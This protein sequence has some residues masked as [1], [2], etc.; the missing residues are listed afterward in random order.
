M[1]KLIR[2][3][4]AI[5][6]LLAPLAATAQPSTESLQAD[7]SNRFTV[8]VAGP[9]DA[10]AGIV[11]V[12]DWFGVS[13][14]YLDATQRLA[15]KGYRVVAV[16]LYEGRH[17]TT[18][19]EAG[20]LMQSMDAALAAKKIDAAVQ[21]LTTGQPRKVGIMGFSMGGKPALEAAMRNKAIV[22]STIWY[23]ETITHPARLK[24]LTGPV[25]LVVGSKDGPAA[26]SNAA[27]LSRAADDAG[28]K[29][30]IFVYPGAAHAFAQPLFNQ[31][32]TYDAA[33]ADVAWRLTE[34]FFARQL[35]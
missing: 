1:N 16:D 24:K 27:A 4:I 30:E 34:S 31:G 23:G 15:E 10:K 2:R 21:S 9:A 11:L 25:L 19:D 12:H 8:H 32:K 17:A 7:S 5:L 20:A 26:A 22:A 13:R 29:A 18:H 3:Q 6:S 28:A 14:F 35:K 33:A